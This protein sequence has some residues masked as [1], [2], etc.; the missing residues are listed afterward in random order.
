WNGLGSDGKP[1]PAGDYHFQVT[2]TGDGGAAVTAETLVRGR[3]T[4]VKFDQGVTYLMVGTRS[5]GLSDVVQ[6][7]EAGAGS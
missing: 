4:G 6:I 5:I 2:A 3:V 1:V 7:E